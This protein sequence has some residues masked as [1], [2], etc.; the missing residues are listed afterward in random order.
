MVVIPCPLLE[1]VNRSTVGTAFLAIV[2][3]S[4][5]SKVTLKSPA[6]TARSP[7]VR[8]KSP[9]VKITLAVPSAEPENVAVVST[10]VENTKS[11]VVPGVKS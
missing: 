4:P 6:D 5:A 1:M 3:P 11:P 2:T 7:S 9:A 8:V 10:S